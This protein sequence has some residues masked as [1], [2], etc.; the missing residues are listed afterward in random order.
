MGPS[1]TRREALV[2]AGATMAAGTL[3]VVPAQAADP[4]RVAAILPFSGGLELF[5]TQAK[6]GLDLALTEI[7]AAGGVLGRP[8][9]IDYAD[10]K[11]DPER[12]ASLVRGMVGASNPIAVVG[13][14]SSGVRD[15]MMPEI[16]KAEV[17]LLYA[18]NYE[19]GVCNPWFFCFNT[20]PNQETALVLPWLAE[21]FG[22]RFAMLGSD[23]VWPRNMFDA[24]R[25]IVAKSGG[26]T[27]DTAF[28]PLG[29]R[30]FATSIQRISD[31]RPDVLVLAV[32]GADGVA[33]VRQANQARLF[34]DIALNFM[35]FEQPY[36]S[37]TGP[38]S[39]KGLFV[40][41]PLVPGADT[42]G[43]QSF[44]AAIRRQAGADASASEYALTHYNAIHALAEGLKREGEISR[45]AV[46]RGMAGL[47]IDS[48][49][50]PV[51]ID[52]GTHH[53][54]LPMFLG[55]AKGDDFSMLES[56][57]PVAPMPNCSN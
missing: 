7:N 10:D 27:L 57:G 35:G 8:L 17:P 38:I 43:V 44:V 25:A 29:E 45:E 54:T 34:E 16:L 19:G 11:T 12:G 42:A 48:P 23:Y 51:A 37:E 36:L 2:A 39:G 5:G 56:F 6:L 40:A 30:D 46:V 9:A 32:P 49:T 18:T 47:T 3:E 26:Q 53:V 52:A 15:A 21:R 4:L 28:V 13:P 50:G 33:F 14:V 31:L 1:L 55:E 20:V 41:T 24:A 22:P